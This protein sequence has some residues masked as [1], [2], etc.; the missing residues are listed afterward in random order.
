MTNRPWQD[1][2][3]HWLVI[4]TVTALV[5]L[6]CFALLFAVA[7]NVLRGN[8]P[9]DDVLPSFDLTLSNQKD[10][11][12]LDGYIDFGVTQ[13]LSTLLEQEDS[14]VHL[15]LQSRGGL[16]AEARGL[17]RLVNE[18]GLST[19]AYGD[20]ASACTLVFIAGQTRYLEPDARLGFHRYAQ[21]S[22]VMEFLMKQNPEEEQQRDL[23]LFRR[24]NVDEAFLTR[25]METPHQSMWYP[26]VSELIRSGVVDV[27]GVPGD[28]PGS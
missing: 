4:P 27:L 28:H 15:R 21:K 3:L 12:R 1:N 17:V 10:H 23:N 7:A 11:I 8:A 16:V 2:R 26:S 13:A 6:A 5:G 19:S 14:V 18:F 9:D 20:C 24:A 25:I 22:P